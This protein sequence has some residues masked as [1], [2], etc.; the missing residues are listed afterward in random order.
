APDH[1]HA[2]RAAGRSQR[3][4][5][6]AAAQ[7]CRGPASRADAALVCRETLLSYTMLVRSKYHRVRGYFWVPGAL[8]DFDLPD[9]AALVA[10]RLVLWL[11]GID[12]MAEP[13]DEDEAA[14]IL[15]WPASMHAALGE[16]NRLQF[17]R[18]PSGASDE[19]AQA[20]L[21]FLQKHS[22]AVGG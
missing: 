16:R 20:I 5:D 18:T 17:A 13:V 19:A 9:L 22:D 1:A 11:D 2:H 10:P 3:A 8:H 6:A 21:A 14:G 4:G 12:A 7:G 15:R